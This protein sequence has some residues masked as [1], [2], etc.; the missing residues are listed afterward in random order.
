MS[1]DAAAASF[2]RS[3]SGPSPTIFN[4][5]GRA[6]RFHASRSVSIPFSAER[7]PAKIA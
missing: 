7:R 2:T 6:S 5:K 1:G 4:G 3:A